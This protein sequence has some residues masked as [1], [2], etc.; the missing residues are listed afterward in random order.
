[1]EFN[2]E[3]DDVGLIL[4]VG[5][6][7]CMEIVE[8]E[9]IDR[10]NEVKKVS[11]ENKWEKSVIGEGEV[12][13]MENIGIK[14]EVEDKVWEKE[15]S[16]VEDWEV[17]E[18]KGKERSCGCVK[19]GKRKKENI[20]E[21]KG[22]KVENGIDGWK[23]DIGKERIIDV[24]MNIE[25]WD[26]KV[27]FLKNVEYEEEE[28]G[29]LNEDEIIE[30]DVDEIVENEFEKIK[31]GKGFKRRGERKKEKDWKDGIG[32]V[33]VF[34]GKG[35]KGRK[36]GIEINVVIKKEGKE[37]EKKESVKIKKKEKGES[38][39]ERKFKRVEKEIGDRWDLKKKEVDGLR[40]KCGM[41]GEIKE[42]NEKNI[43][44]RLRKIMKGDGF[45]ES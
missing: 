28:K 43:G 20:S 45:D 34:M 22:R 12:I 35:E 5:K 39:K 38:V 2:E 14:I 44:M 40:I 13:V 21:E 19:N 17:M 24:G 41:I 4:E 32:V 11:G 23:D 8:K 6:M 37:E 26:L 9:R 25:W 3:I 29:I 16:E 15:K 31:I 36:I 10:K 1:M 42:K 33:E 30:I 7:D 18:R 27:E